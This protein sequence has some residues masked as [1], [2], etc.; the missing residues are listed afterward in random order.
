MVPELKQACKA[1]EQNQK[2]K[3]SKHK[4]D[5]RVPRLLKSCGPYNCIRMDGRY[6]GV[7]HG[8]EVD[9]ATSPLEAGDD[10]IEGDT[11]EA[12]METIATVLAR[13]ETTARERMQQEQ[14]RA[15]A[16]ARIPHLVESC[17]PYNCIRM[18]GRYFGVRHGL[19]V[20][21]ATS[22]LKEGDDLIEGD[23]LEAVRLEIKRQLELE[24]S[25]E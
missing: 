9:W 14:E 20:D 18:D 11:L 13:E 16:Q 4:P 19:E 2:E 17:G 25:K 8:L 6:F 15:K 23:T 3:P 1:A 7:R 10:L 12:V 21:W 22:P 5:N 24:Y